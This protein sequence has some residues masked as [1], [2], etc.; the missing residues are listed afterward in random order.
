LEGAMRRIETVGE[1]QSPAA[2]R[3][4]MPGCPMCGQGRM[5]MPHAIP[6][7]K[8]LLCVP[9]MGV[10][11]ALFGFIVGLWFGGSRRHSRHTPAT[12]NERMRA[13]MSAR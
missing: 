5:G 10:I 1:Q 7:S 6:P 9:V 2:C 8:L 12:W 11:P 13:A 4:A 3:G